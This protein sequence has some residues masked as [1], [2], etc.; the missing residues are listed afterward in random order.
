MLSTDTAGMGIWTSTCVTSIILAP[1]KY[2]STSLTQKKKKEKKNGYCVKCCERSCHHQHLGQVLL[3]FA[4]VGGYQLLGVYY[5]LLHLR[6]HQCN[7]LFQNE[8]CCL[9]GGWNTHFLVFIHPPILGAV[10][11]TEEVWYSQ[12]LQMEMEGQ[13]A[14]ITNS[15]NF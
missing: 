4:E 15:L 10:E 7:S 1:G 3:Q 8:E 13:S 2:V 12:K 5:W 11:T 6:Y 9:T 14:P